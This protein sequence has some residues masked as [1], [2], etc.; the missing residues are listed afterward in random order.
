MFCVYMCT[1]LLLANANYKE[2]TNY[3]ISNL[4]FLE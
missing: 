2:K 1:Y 3:V 4:L